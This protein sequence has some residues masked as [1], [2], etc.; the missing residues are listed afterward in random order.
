MRSTDFIAHFVQKVNFGV[1]LDVY[2]GEKTLN[3]VVEHRTGKARTYV[4]EEYGGFFLSIEHS[5]EICDMAAHFFNEGYNAGSVEINGTVMQSGD[6]MAREK[7][8]THNFIVEHRT[9][10]V[11]TYVSQNYR[12]RILK[13][14]GSE[15]CDISAHFFN[16]GRKAAKEG[17]P[18]E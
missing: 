13:D 15:L 7:G 18:N 8:E 4:S 5:Q 2:E 14:C 1:L 12:L 3:F 9:G 6:L 16:E 11:C 10:K 17:I